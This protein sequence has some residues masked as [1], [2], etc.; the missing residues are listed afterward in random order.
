MSMSTLATLC[1]FSLQ[2]T[3]FWDHLRVRI[4]PILTPNWVSEFTPLAFFMWV[5]SFHP[6]LQGNVELYLGAPLWWYKS[7]PPPLMLVSQA[8]PLCPAPS[9]HHNVE[10][11]TTYINNSW[12][13]FLFTVPPLLEETQD[14]MMISVVFYGGI[15]SVLWVNVWVLQC[16]SDDVAEVAATVQF[17]LPAW[18]SYTHFRMMWPSHWTSLQNPR[19]PTGSLPLHPPLLTCQHWE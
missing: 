1:N 4:T 17:L 16:L 10:Y 6:F 11:S 13:P 14:G 7:C 19:Q 5:N 2:S 9:T 3:S 12:V 15:S 18:C 8:I